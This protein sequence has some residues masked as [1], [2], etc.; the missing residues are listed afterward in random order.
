MYRR[1]RS[2][3]M[4]F[5]LLALPTLVLAA[6]ALK[7]TGPSGQASDVPPPPASPA[8]PQP[9]DGRPAGSSSGAAQGGACISPATPLGALPPVK[10]IWCQPAISGGASTFKQSDR[11][12]LDDFEHGLSNAEMGAGYRV[13]DTQE[14]VYRTQHFRHNNHWMMDLAPRDPQG[15]GGLLG[16]GMVRPDRAFRFQQGRLVVETDAAAG[17]EEYGTNGADIWPEIVVTT[18]PA[19]TG[20]I[21]DPLYAYGQ[22][23]GHW[24]FGCRLQPSREPVCALYDK[25][26]TNHEG[27][28]LFGTSAGRVWEM[29]HFQHVGTQV[30][31]GYP[32]GG[33]ENAWRVCRGAD[34]DTT[35]RD[36]FRLELTRDSVTLSVNGVRYFEQRGLRRPFPDALVNGEVYVYFAGW[37]VRQRAEVIR[38]H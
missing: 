9:N 37:Q 3:V 4:S 22:F 14:A 28:G 2:L 25:D 17:I 30:Y 11:A 13:F 23:G 15:R 27:N 8:S 19:P 33:L 16:G 26:P 7:V 5:A 38:F 21:P 20:K 31:G 12:W 24:S 6:L 29:S 18:A 32:S 1:T 36:R 10:A 35:C 34:P